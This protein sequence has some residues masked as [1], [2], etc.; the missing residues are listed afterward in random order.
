M[1]LN[2]VTLPCT[3]YAASVAFYKLLG[4]RRIVDSPASYARFECES[5]ATFVLHTAPSAKLFK[6]S[7]CKR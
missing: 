3:G 4:F 5:G 6:A 7:P 1:N 2:Q